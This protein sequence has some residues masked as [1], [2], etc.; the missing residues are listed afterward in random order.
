MVEGR[1]TRIGKSKK[2]LYVWLSIT[3]VQQCPRKNIPLKA[4]LCWVSV[5]WYDQN[6]MQVIHILFL[7]SN[8]TGFFLKD[9]PPYLCSHPTVQNP[10]RNLNSQKSIRFRTNCR[11]NAV[12]HQLPLHIFSRTTNSS[13]NGLGY[14]NCNGETDLTRPFFLDSAFSSWLCVQH[15]KLPVECV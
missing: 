3:P 15:S 8:N 7:R 11:A 13:P 10:R 4:F 1:Y 9:V 2:N 5:N 12:S 6:C 14:H